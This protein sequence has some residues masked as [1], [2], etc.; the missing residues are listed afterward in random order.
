MISPED[1]A[2]LQRIATRLGDQDNL[3]TSEVCFCVQKQT[4]TSGIDESLVDPDEI[5]WVHQGQAMSESHW[6][7]ITLARDEGR[8]RVTLDGEEYDMDEMNSYGF[9]R[10]WETVQVCFTHEGAEK[11]LE[12]NG[13]NL[14][15]YGEPRIYGESFHRNREMIVLRKLLPELAKLAALAAQEDRS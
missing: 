13:H 6:P 5:M 9:K 3:G 8:D 15:R 1:L 14:R 7:L 4:F 2:E 10:D 12:A 11:Y